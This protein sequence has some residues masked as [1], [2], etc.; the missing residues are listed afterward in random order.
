[1]GLVLTF[2]DS[3]EFSRVVKLDDSKSLQV[4]VLVQLS[5]RSRIG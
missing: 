2:L 1:M 5:G 3:Y 4:L